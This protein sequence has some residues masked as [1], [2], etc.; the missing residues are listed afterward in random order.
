MAAAGTQM[1]GATFDRR[2]LAVHRRRCA[3]LVDTFACKVVS[4]RDLRGPSQ[5]IDCEGWLANRNSRSNAGERRL[6]E[7]SGVVPAK[8][9]RRR[10][11]RA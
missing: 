7:A 4:S 11:L 8:S 5:E 10:D 1:K 9:R 6:V 2:Y 3:A